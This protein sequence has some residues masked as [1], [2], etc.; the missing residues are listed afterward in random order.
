[1]AA[2]VY[3]L[4]EEM[5]PGETT[6]PWTKIGFTKNPPEWRFDTNLKRGNP[7]KVIV[8]EAFE[9]ETA[10]LARAAEK[11]AHIAFASVEHQKEWFRIS[12]Q[13]ALAWF[14][15]QGAVK[16]AIAAQPDVQDD[17]PE[18]VGLSA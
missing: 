8:A 9:Y 2:Y 14:L 16:R 13:E 6:G 10:G 4:H 7:R 3:L 15:S 1:M 11:A 5:I 12:W 18:E 17:Q